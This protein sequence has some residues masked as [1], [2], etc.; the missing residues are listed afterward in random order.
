MSIRA[1]ILTLIR[2]IDLRRI[3]G[4]G[5][6]ACIGD[7]RNTY[8][9][10]VVKPGGNRLLGKLRKRWENSMIIGLTDI[11]CVGVGWIKCGLG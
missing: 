7:N 6:T 3:R 8:W 11:F 4:A 2:V 10:L 9:G 5:H 1:F